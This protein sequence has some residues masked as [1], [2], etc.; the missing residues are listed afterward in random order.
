MKTLYFENIPSDAEAAKDRNTEKNTIMG[1]GIYFGEVFKALLQY[2]TYER[3]LLPA[4]PRPAEGD[5]RDSPLFAEN[6]HRIM[7]LPENE[8]GILREMKHVVLASPAVNLLK[9]MRIRRAASRP[10]TPMTG[11]V[12]SINYFGQLEMML[13]VIFSRVNTFDALLCSSTAGAQAIRNYIQI[14]GDRIEQ[15]GLGEFRPPIKTPVI[16]LGVHTAQF[17]SRSRSAREWLS[18]GEGIVL[19]YFG[20]LSATG[21]ADL[22]PLLMIYSEVYH[23]HPNVFLVLAGDDTQFGMAKD[24]EEF[25][26]VLGCRSNVRVVPN[27]TNIQKRELL[28]AGDVFVSLADSLQET[29]GITLAEAMAAGLPVVASDWDGYKDIVESG[30]T[31][32]LVPTFMP[33]FS[34][35][36]DELYGS[37]NTKAPDLLAATTVVDTAVLKQVLIKL[38]TDTEHR[39]ELGRA[40]Q[41]RARARYDWKAVIERY[42]NLWAE[43]VEEAA[44]APLDLSRMSFTKWRYQDIFAH[45]PTAFLKPETRVAISALGREWR[46]KSPLIGKLTASN[47][48]NEWF[49]PEEL[50]SIMDFLVAR[51]D[52]SFAEVIAFY[53]TETEGDSIRPLSHLCRLLKYGLVEPVSHP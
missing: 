4:S 1:A 30:K 15:I 40:A 47:N 22:Y 23:K 24:L 32:Y 44:V 26:S 43:L 25:A 14:I 34:S 41:T 3:I 36:A 48:S 21:K 19:L 20:R 38:I 11:V 37:G 5:L 17:A 13:P 7:L 12:H 45:Y 42:E 35:Q 52:A 8:L 53:G 28:A 16:P 49:Q 46:G 51:E 39:L 9:L 33:Q 31:G 2:S 27:P 18:I 50:S 29:F 6:A 10:R